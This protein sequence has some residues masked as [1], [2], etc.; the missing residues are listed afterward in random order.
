MTSLTSVDVLQPGSSLSW[1]ACSSV[2]KSRSAGVAVDGQTVGRTDRQADR[3]TD[4]SGRHRPGL[5]LG[6]GLGGHSGPELRGEG[7]SAGMSAHLAGSSV[8][9]A[10]RNGQKR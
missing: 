2:W 7:T 4:R 10:R 5:G 8:V 1:W 9:N 3:Q 6:E